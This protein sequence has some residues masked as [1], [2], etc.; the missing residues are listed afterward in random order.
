MRARVEIKSLTDGDSFDV[1]DIEIHVL[2]K[3]DKMRFYNLL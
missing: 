3:I 1:Y 2:E